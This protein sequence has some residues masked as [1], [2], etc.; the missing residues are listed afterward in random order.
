[1]ITFSNKI[2]YFHFLF[3]KPPFRADTLTVMTMNPM[4]HTQ[5][6]QRSSIPMIFLHMSIMK[7]FIVMEMTRIVTMDIRLRGVHAI[8]TMMMTMA[9]VWVWSW[10]SNVKMKF[11]LHLHLPWAHKDPH[12]RKIKYKFM[13]TSKQRRRLCVFAMKCYTH[14]LYGT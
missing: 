5:I 8:L 1:L 13:S 14:L 2:F 4:I 6:F 11:L 9:V 10:M 12:V 7:D 3:P